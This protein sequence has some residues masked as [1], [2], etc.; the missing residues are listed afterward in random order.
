MK[1]L[2]LSTAVPRNKFSTEELLEVFPCKLPEGIKQNVLNLGVSQR[3]LIKHADSSPEQETIMSETDLVDLCH[4]ACEKTIKK[5][6]L[7]VKDIGYFIMTYDQNPILCPGLSQLVTRRLGFNSYVKHVNLQGMACT[8]FTK[9]LE[10][11]EDH[12]AAH[13]EDYVL[14]CISGVNSY[15]F[16]NQVRGIKDIREISKISM[17]KNKDKR[18]MELRKWI[19]TMEFFLFGDGVASLIV[20]SNGD[21]PS[22]NKTVEV[23]N[24][25]K[26]DY[27]AGYGRLSALNEP[28]RFGFYSYLDK[29]IPKLGVEYTS[30]VLRKLLGKNHE[31]TMKA[32][33]KLAVHT[34]SEKILN[35]IAKRYKILDEKLKESYEVLREY[36]NLAGGSLP[37]IMERIVSENKFSI[38]DII[39]MLGYGWGFSAAACMLEFQE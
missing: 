8:A 33:K 30:L 17:I 21:G 14:I 11:A 35:R 15:W 24:V 34:G 12:L 3:H 26:K 22:V 7:S 4:E 2:Q 29:E 1:I 19:A 31:K 9:A 38:G 28:F 10:L 20:A 39:L 37:F 16:Y 27:L 5:T 18:Q 32:A 36:G 6:S 23:T 13:P 25:R